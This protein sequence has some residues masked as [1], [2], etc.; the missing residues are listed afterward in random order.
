M[1]FTIEIVNID[2]EH[3]DLQIRN[4]V[5]VAFNETTI[6]TSFHIA[7]N[8]KSNASRPGFML[9]AKYNDE[10]VGCNAFLPYDFTLNNQRWVGYQ[11]CW[12]A[13]HPDHQGKGIFAAIINEAKQK[14]K[15]EGAGFIYGMANDNS[16]SI[17]VNKLG[18][19]EIP[20]VV[21][22]IPGIPLLKTARLTTVATDK[23]DICMVDEAQVKEHK[24]MQFPAEVKCIHYKDSWIWG[25]LLKKI[26]NGITIPVFY[27]GGF[28]LA[29]DAD[30]KPLIAKV[31]EA[32][33]IL[34]LQVLS[35]GS[36]SLNVLFKGWRPA[37]VN[38]FIFYNLNMPPARHFNIMQ[39][40]IDV[41]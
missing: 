30:I 17:F 10:I 14:L 23:I 16:H 8:I 22:R 32:E 31:F 34:L 39:G 37:K 35:C 3:T 5:Q 20:A 18:F 9:A 15:A 27:A 1:S 25:K 36:N 40:I 19:S 29:D 26:K 4:L 7:N 38:P 28:H 21:T 13:T 2:D 24:G 12:S 41:F 6:L 33:K 11:S